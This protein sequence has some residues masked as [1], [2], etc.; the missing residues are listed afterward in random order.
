M[1]GL[2]NAI[3][4]SVP[5][6]APVLATSTGIVSAVWMVAGAGE[7]LMLKRV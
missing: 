7:A 3:T 6:I 1:C 2:K 5:A 4:V